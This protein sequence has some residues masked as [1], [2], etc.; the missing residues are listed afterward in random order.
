MGGSIRNSQRKSAVQPL[1]AQSLVKKSRRNQRT[2]SPPHSA[3]AGLGPRF[4]L[5]RFQKRSEENQLKI[6][7]QVLFWKPHR[8]VYQ[9]PRIGF[10]C[11]TGINR[12]RIHFE[13]LHSN[14]PN[15]RNTAIEI[16]LYTTAGTVEISPRN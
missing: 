1:Q 9:I 13:N 5:G 8:R 16:V 4:L 7:V 10:E 3:I 15:Q 11:K 6:T 2:I 14:P 12:H